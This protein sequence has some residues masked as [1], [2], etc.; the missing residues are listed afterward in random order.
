MACPN[1]RPARRGAA[2]LGGLVVAVGLVCRAS[3]EPPAA[4][5][6][7]A[8]KLPPPM[9]LDAAIRTALEQNPGI[10]AVRQDHGVAEAGVM[11]ARAYPFNPVWEG[12]FRYAWPVFE[13]ATNQEPVESTVTTEVEVRGQRTIRQAQAQ[14]TLSHRLGDRDPGGFAGRP[15]G[16]R[17]RHGRLPLPE[18]QARPGHDRAEPADVRGR[19]GPGE[20]G[21]VAAGRPDHSAHRDRRRAPCSARAASRWRRR[22]AN[23]G[24]RWEW[25]AARRWC[26]TAI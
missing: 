25:S 13:G 20:G 7:D 18:K 1:R 21:P 2:W 19:R 15:R 11:I 9:T 17:L 3:A 26:C 12:R 4:P 22:R 5:P 16:P 14:A 10:L 24:R 8:A 6:A 23:C